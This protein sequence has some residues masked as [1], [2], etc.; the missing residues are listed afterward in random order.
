MFCLSVS[1]KVFQWVT[2]LFFLTHPKPFCSAL[3]YMWI[4][5]HPILERTVL[6]WM[7]KSS[8]LCLRLKE[9]HNYLCTGSHKT[10]LGGTTCR[11]MLFLPFCLLALPV[12]LMSKILTSFPVNFS[13]LGWFRKNLLK[14]LHSSLHSWI[15]FQ[16]SSGKC[17]SNKISFQDS[18]FLFQ[19][20]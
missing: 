5:F 18:D 17:T 7:V 9:T 13:Q 1:L 10:M 14:L 15:A 20:L 12:H 8:Y 4:V 2:N 11:K 19:L 3:V 16:G 6:Q